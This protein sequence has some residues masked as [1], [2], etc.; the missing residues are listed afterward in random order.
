M[1]LSS[2]QVA[3]SSGGWEAQSS[4]ALASAQPAVAQVSMQPV[5]ALAAARAPEALDDASPWVPVEVLVQ[6]QVQLGAVELPAR[7]PARGLAAAWEPAAA[8]ML[9]VAAVRPLLL[10]R[11]AVLVRPLLLQP[12]AAIATTSSRR[13]RLRWRSPWPLRLP[14]RHAHRKQKTWWLETCDLALAS[15]TAAKACIASACNE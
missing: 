14:C 4:V 2:A 8:W 12:A 3:L 5:R 15:C 9:E 1:A 6:A 10:A 13:P 7:A 11:A